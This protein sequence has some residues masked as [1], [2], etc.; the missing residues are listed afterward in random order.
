MNHVQGSRSANFS[1]LSCW[2]FVCCFLL[3]TVSSSLKA[4]QTGLEQTGNKSGTPDS[5]VN[6]QEN[7]PDT[8]GL[9]T[10]GT[11]SLSL[12][13][14]LQLGE[15]FK[16]K[17]QYHAEDS[18]VYDLE[19]GKAYL[20]SRAWITYEDIRLD[21]D[22]ITIDFNTKVL[23]AS[24]WPDSVGRIAGK[25]IF[26]QGEDEFKADSI[27][28]NFNTKRGKISEI[29]TKDGDSYIHGETVKKESDNTTFI[30]NGYYTTC[31][32][33]HPHYYLRSNRIKVIPN[34]KVVTGPAD[35]HIMDVPTP[36]AIPFG[37]FPNKKGRSSGILF[38]QY[39]ESQ[40]LGFFLRNG[41]Y[42]LGLNDHFDLALTGDIY[43][44]GSWR[45]NAYSNYSWRYRFNGN[46]S[47]NYSKTKVS[48]PEFPDYSEEESFFIRWMHTQDAKARPGMS[49]SANVNAGSSA[50]YQYNLSNSNN[51]LTNTFNSS[52]AWSRSWAGKPFNL[53]TSLTHTQNTQTRD[54]TLSIPSVTFNIARRT[55]F[56]RKTQIGAQ[57]WYEKIGIGLTT[58]FLNSISTKDTL[59][60]KSGSEKNFRYGMQHSVPINTSFTIAKFFNVSPGISYNER[61]YLQTIEKTWDAETKAV[62]IDTLS[63]FKAARDFSFSTSVS[64]RIYG[65]VQFKSSK[66]AAIR[67]VMTPS[68]GFSW[69]PDFSEKGYGYYKQVQVDTTGRTAAYSIFETGVYGGPG[70]GKS[71]LM[72][73]S[74]DNNFEMKVRQ[75]TD[76]AEVMKKV[77]LLESLALSGNYN[78]A[79]DSLRLSTIGV[80]GRATILEKISLNLFGNFDPYAVT[81]EGVRYNTTE[82]K[83]NGKLA[84]FTSGNLSVNFNVTPRRKEVK[85]DKGTESELRDVNTNPDNY[86][87]FNV[88]FTLIVGY[89]FFYQNN[90][91]TPDQT[92]QTLNFSGDVQLTPAWKVSYSSGYDF[93]QK[94]LSYTSLG[95]HRD[96]HCWEM[97]LNW[98]PFGFQQNFFFQINVKSSMLQDLK[99]TRK[100]DRF[101]NR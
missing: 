77:K 65:L 35:L 67:H 6:I 5:V 87:D 81:N 101:D 37:F 100:N 72:N 49:F 86:L 93:Q 1:T 2:W 82:W 26:K 20:Y 38:P 52:V 48:R 70:A 68:V 11:D 50:F 31:E 74:L 97:S 41:G 60:F 76:T 47:V 71:T 59:L 99:L 80:S 64:T 21:A 90:V 19:S 84:R 23:F 61:W 14:S 45:T 44:K 9:L 91:T 17:V 7:T 30:K 13:D 55:P 42:Y 79:A 88:P 69:R 4:Q 62:R 34:N 43:S 92:T 94:D 10:V 39:G 51:F 33:E 73:F 15:D 16:S 63:G 89:N 46:V 57:R 40:Q 24:G 12:N 75:R 56:K 95:I 78:F 29:T 54:I 27:R 58:S 8:T 25:P 36:I 98:V 32:A 53:S 85:S 28:Y 66:I 3:I 96:L 22:F 83:A 18:I